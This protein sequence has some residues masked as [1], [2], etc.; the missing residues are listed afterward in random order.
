MREDGLRARARKRFR[1]TT[2]SGHAQPVAGDVLA[3]QFDAERPN[4]RWLSDTTQF[5]IG[6]S[7]KICRAGILDRLIRDS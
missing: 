1:S 6:S 4:Q 3:R 2:M 7:A 5:V